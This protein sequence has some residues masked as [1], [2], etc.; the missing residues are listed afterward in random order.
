M[1]AAFYDHVKDSSD[2]CHTWLGWLITLQVDVTQQT[3]AE[4]VCVH[5]QTHD[6]LP[7]GW[8]TLGV[9]VVYAYSATATHSENKH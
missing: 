1:W 9:D 8:H 6:N 7:L 4:Y 2:W 3:P 5:V